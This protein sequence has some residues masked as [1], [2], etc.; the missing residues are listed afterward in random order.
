MKKT[1]AMRILDKEKI[2]YKF[3]E[4][5]VGDDVS[6]ENVAKKL[7]EDESFVF[8]TLVTVSNTNEHFVFV[9]AVKDELDL[10]K[11]AKACGVKKLEMIHVKDLLK[12]TGYIRGGCSPIGMKTK[13]RTFIDESCEGKEYIYVSGGKIG[14]QIKINP[15]DLIK[16]CDITVKDI[17]K[18]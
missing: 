15:V 9:V 3:I 2:G 14:T 13:F 1:N 8:K 11:C 7:N 12:T 10:K 4:Y 6:G 5:S 18:G 17:K 16:I